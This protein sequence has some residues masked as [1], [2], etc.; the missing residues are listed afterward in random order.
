MTRGR[1]MRDVTEAC[2]GLKMG[3][4]RWG[5]G[6]YWPGFAWYGHRMVVDA[7]ETAVS[8]RI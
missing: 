2:L 3:C 1:G 5:R 6:P 4:G 8:L 7:T